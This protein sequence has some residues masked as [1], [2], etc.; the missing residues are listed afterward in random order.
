MDRFSRWNIM[1]G[2]QVNSLRLQFYYQLKDFEKVDELIPKSLFIDGTAV[3][4]RI[5][6]MFRRE[7]PKLDAYFK[8]KIRKFSGDQAILLYA[9]YS[10]ILVKQGRLDDAIKVLVKAKDST[11]NEVLK[12]NWEALVNG[13]EKRFSNSGLGEA[14]YVLQLEEPKMVKQQQKRVRNVFR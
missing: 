12:R 10:W 11:D 14:W 9:L 4:M 2:R 1:L 5:A 13:K 3:A 8:K 6:R 7:D